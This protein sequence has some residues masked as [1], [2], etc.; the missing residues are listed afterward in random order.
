MIRETARV[1]CVLGTLA[2][3]ACGGTPATSDAAVSD[4]DAGVGSDAMV[5]VDAAPPVP[6]PSVFGVRSGGGTRAST[7]YSLDV[8][9]GAPVPG[10]QQ[11]SKNYSLILDVGPALQ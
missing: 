3:V 8:S 10:T 7:N 2:F 4:F 6:I 11:T 1:L 9:I 5:D